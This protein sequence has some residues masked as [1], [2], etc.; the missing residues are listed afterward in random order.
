MT[1]SETLKRLKLDMEYHPAESEN[2]FD[3]GARL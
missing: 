1:K 3:A 2:K